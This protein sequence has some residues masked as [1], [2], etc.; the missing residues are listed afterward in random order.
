MPY[1]VR[2]ER[3]VSGPLG[4]ILQP[5]SRDAQIE[6]LRAMDDGQDEAALWERGRDP[7]VAVVEQLQ[8]VVVLAAV[9]LRHGLQRGHAGT[10]EIGGV[11]EFD[12]VRLEGSAV[13]LAVSE[14]RGEIGFEDRGDVRRDRY[15]LDH[16]LGNTAA[17]AVPAAPAG[18]RCAGLGA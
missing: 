15:A 10:D 9:D 17:H 13:G 7:D 14:D 18:L 6:R 4:Q 3:T 5:L 8:R 16:V 12:P 2:V 11:G 1:L